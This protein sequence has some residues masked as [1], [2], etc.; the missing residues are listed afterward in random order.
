MHF[1]P[2]RR[3]ALFSLLPLLAVSFALSGGALA[4]TAPPPIVPAGTIVVAPAAPVEP[5]PNQQQQQT[6]APPAIVQ[7]REDEPAAP[8]APTPPTE[9]RAGLGAQIKALLGGSAAHAQQLATRD[10]QITQLLAD[11]A[12]AR[13]TI[14]DQG[15]ELQEL[16]S[17]RDDLQQSVGALTQQATTAVDIVASLGFEQS[18]LPAR[19]ELPAETAG[20]LEKQIAACTDPKKAYQ[21]Q[22]RLDALGAK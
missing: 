21:L 20:E 13:Q 17:L 16:R 5:A 8:P 4:E 14:A 18:H 7:R 10:G 15:T 3:F 11:L 22:T 12:A 2:R 1:A 6:P 19:T 9:P